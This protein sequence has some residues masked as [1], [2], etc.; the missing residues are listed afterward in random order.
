MASTPMRPSGA[1]IDQ[2]IAIHFDGD[3][4]LYA[5][6]AAACAE[7]FVV[8]VATA[9]AA[10]A[11]GDLARLRRLGHDLKSAL[12]VL[13]HAEASALAA[14]LE[15]RAQALDLAA[16]RDAWRALERALPPPHGT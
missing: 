16:A 14:A 1:D 11:S 10:C 7:Q 12:V 5:A 15:Q 6:F 13:G 2:A 3:K 8:D 9:R 4:A